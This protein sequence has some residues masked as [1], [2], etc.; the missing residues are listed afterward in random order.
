MKPQVTWIVKEKKLKISIYI[1]DFLFKLNKNRRLFFKRTNWND[2]KFV[3]NHIESWRFSGRIQK[4]FLLFEN[5]NVEQSGYFAL[6][7]STKS[8]VAFRQKMLPFGPIKWPKKK[9]SES[10]QYKLHHYL[11]GQCQTS[12]LFDCAVKIDTV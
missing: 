1:C 9:S 5:A 3:Y 12:C 7:A 6:R 11:L 4:N 10:C 8:N 2:E